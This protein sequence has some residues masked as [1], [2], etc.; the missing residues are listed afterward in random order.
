[1]ATL[2]SDFGRE[3]AES[4]MDPVAEL[5]QGK[6]LELHISPP[7]LNL[8]VEFPATV[9]ITRGFHALSSHGIKEIDNSGLSYANN[10]TSAVTEKRYSSYAFRGVL[11]ST[12]GAYATDKTFLSRFC[13]KTP[14]PEEEMRK[15]FLVRSEHIATKILMALELISIKKSL[16]SRVKEGD[17]KIIGDINALLKI[18]PEWSPLKFQEMSVEDVDRWNGW[19]TNWYEANGVDETKVRSKSR[20]ILRSGC[21]R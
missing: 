11:D 5:L 10:I 3:W 8:G 21:V 2:K 17:R 6:S 12:L 1:M 20:D 7:E 4:I 18:A 13:P 19:L 16:Q 15:R 9:E 14:L